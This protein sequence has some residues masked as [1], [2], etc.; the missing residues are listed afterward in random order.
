MTKTWS[1]SP[2]SLGLFARLSR[3]KR[4][5]VH[6]ALGKSAVCKK[7]HCDLQS[8]DLPEETF[9]Q[10]KEVRIINVFQTHSSRRA[11]YDKTSLGREYYLLAIFMLP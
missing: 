7:S 4:P 6:L 10:D 5:S 9:L 3:L 1:L 2:L 8:V 11:G